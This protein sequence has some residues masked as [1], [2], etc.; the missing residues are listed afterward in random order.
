MR[1]VGAL[2]GI[3]LAVQAAEMKPYEMDWKNNS[4]GLVDISFLLEPPAGRGGFI[5]AKDGH[6]V[7]PDGRRFRIW[8]V[9]FTAAACT[10][11][12]E[13]TPVVAAHLTR[14]GLN[15]VR[16]HFLDRTAPNG[17]VDAARDDARALDPAQLDRLDFFIAELKRRGIYTNLNLNVGRTY[18]AGDGVRDFELL[19]FAKALTYFDARLLELQREYAR[20]LLTHYNPYTKAEYRNEA[21]VAIVELVNENSI[22]ESW[23]SNR[24]L[25]KATRKNPGTWT[26]IPA[27]Y[28]EALTAK[29]HAW[30]KQRG[31][32]PVPRLRREEFAAAPRERF[33]T[34]AAFYMEMEERYFQSMYAYLKKELGVKPLVVGTSDHNHGASGYPLLH[35][36]AKLDV[37]DGHVYWQH[38]RYTEDAATGRRTGF[39]IRNTPMVEDPFNSTVVELSRSAVAGKPYTVSEVNHPFPAEH[40]AEG[41]PI[42]AAYAAFQDWDGIFWY[43]FEHFVP[44]KWGARQPGHFELRP[45]PVKMTQLAAGAL[46]FLR[47]D[48]RPALKTL[49]RTYSLEQVV[50]SLRLPRTERPYFTPGFPLSLPLRHAVRIAGFASPV[51][52]QFPAQEPLP[53]VSD[54]GE[55]T[56]DQGWVTI[57]SPRAQ[58]LIGRVSQKGRALE[59]LSAE[60]ENGFC[61]ITLTSLDGAPLARSARMLLTTGARVANSGMEWN[62]KRT[63]LTNWGTAPTVIEPVTGAVLLRNLAGARKVEAL[64]LDSAARPLGQPIAAQRTVAGWRIP[65]GTPATPWYLIRVGR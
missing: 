9:N 48:V 41:I 12:K 17:L 60:V 11:S 62:E 40:A 5:R 23:F 10:P 34:E 21:A 13:D 3:G 26:D 32:P 37:V 49:T 55:L 33:H 46:V 14:F 53:L 7:K 42:L 65:L 25:G 4:G 1:F 29:Y 61:A 16:F 57:Q 56:W 28:E 36:T 18:K 63:S 45:D 44:A 2:I 59:N 47:A 43:T 20:Q 51:H 52:G 15:C 30:L 22:V 6:L 58:G 19:G 64:P 31:E 50:E 54:T 38:P 39:E 8:G 27:S 24:L 35:S